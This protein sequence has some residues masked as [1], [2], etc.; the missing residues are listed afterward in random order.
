MAVCRAATRG[1]RRLGPQISSTLKLER[2]RGGVEDGLWRDLTWG[3]GLDYVGED[4]LAELQRYGD[5]MDAG[6]RTEPRERALQLADVVF[7]MS[8]DELEDILGQFGLF[9]FSFLPQ[10]RQACFEL[11]GWMSVISPDSNRL[12]SLSSSV[13][14]ARGWRSDDMTT[15]L[16]AS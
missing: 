10:D 11:G 1:R 3:T 4:V 13:A 6:V 15:C 8:G 9:S 7:D 5:S 12:R 14:M 16:S 2:L